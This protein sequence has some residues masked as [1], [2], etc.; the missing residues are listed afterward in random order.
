MKERPIK[1]GPHPP[2]VPQGQGGRAGYHR[3]V[4]LFY[5]IM[6]IGASLWQ[7]K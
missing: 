5:S 1:Q 3:R 7:R 4:Y 6:T 2:E